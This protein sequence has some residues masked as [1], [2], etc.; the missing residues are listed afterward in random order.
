[1]SAQLLI[2]SAELD[3]N[4]LVVDEISKQQTNEACHLDEDDLE[5]KRLQS[6]RQT[7]RLMLD[8]AYPDKNSSASIP[9]RSEDT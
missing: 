3:F 9:E 1:M 5:D 4:D 6:K 7:D 8:Y 2:E